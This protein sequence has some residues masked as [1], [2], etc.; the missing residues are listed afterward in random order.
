MFTLI[1]LEDRVRVHPRD[2]GKMRVQ[3]VTDE[4]NIK[5]SNKVKH[6]VGLCIC[7]YD[8]LSISDGVVHPVQ[9]GAYMVTVKFRM[10]VFRPFVDEVIVG[11]VANSSAAGI[12][13]SLEF[14]DDILIPPVCMQPGCE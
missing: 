11:K 13:V 7:V 10:I 3:A 14:F 4:L 9:D 5:Y 2:L 1:K 12:K 6:E 8:V